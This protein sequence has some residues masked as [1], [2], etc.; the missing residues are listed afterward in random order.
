MGYIQMV[1]STSIKLPEPLK[2]RIQRLAEVSGRSAHA[3][4]LEALEREVAREEKLAAF[5]AEALASDASID[6]GADV[7]HAEDVHT[8]IKRLASGEQTRR[9]EPWR[10]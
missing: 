5:V 1:I 7:Y 9:P 2:K 10:K 6:A 3:V 4:M 8:W